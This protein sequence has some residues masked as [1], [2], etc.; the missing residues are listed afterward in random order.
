MARTRFFVEVEYV[1]FEGEK[2]GIDFL[3]TL[4]KTEAETRLNIGYQDGSRFVVVAVRDEAWA[5]CA[6]RED[7]EVYGG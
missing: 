7:G 6:D 5:R 4:M 2:T 3:S 1:P